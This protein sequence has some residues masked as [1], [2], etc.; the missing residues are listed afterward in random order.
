[1][2]TINSH[3]QEVYGLFRRSNTYDKIEENDL[4]H[5]ESDYSQHLPNIIGKKLMKN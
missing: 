2:V 3:V 1:M 4:F 5:I